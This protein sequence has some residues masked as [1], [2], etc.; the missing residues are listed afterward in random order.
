MTPTLASH[1]GHCAIPL[2]PFHARK[3]HYKSRNGCEACKRRKKKCDELPHGCSGCL[4][5]AIPCHYHD[6]SKSLSTG[7]K[8]SVHSP[9][10]V[11]N[12]R[13]VLG[14]SSDESKLLHHFHTQ[15][16][17]TLGSSSVQEVIAGC[18]P[19]VLEFDYLKHAVF[20]L[21]AS[22]LVF[23]SD[24]HD[25]SVNHYLD[26]TLLSFRQ[27]LS[28]PISAFQV[29]AVLTSCVLLNSI[30]F[31]TGSRRSSKSWLFNGT[32][33]LQWLNLQSGLRA[34]MF[35][36]RHLLRES[37]WAAV[38]SKDAECIRGRTGASFDGESLGFERIPEKF[39]DLFRMKQNCSS[40][41]NAYD[42]PLRSLVPLLTSDPSSNSLTQLMAV[43]HRFKPEFL[44][45]IQSR[46]PRALL[47]LAHW[48]GLM[49]QVDLWWVSS[50]SRSECFA[51]CKYLDLVGDD[52]IR[53]LLSFPAQCCGYELDSGTSNAWQ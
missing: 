20:A 16:L 30:V 14:F 12:N 15:T 22:H 27:T 1:A 5:A 36:I 25:Q 33:N 37:S 9:S 29:D 26:K 35:D 47:L 4:R 6:A 49:C 28:S 11:V 24:R 40:W 46:D 2:K 21:A 41:D 50:R 18:L 44:Q 51:C 8:K 32:A 31:S 39:E 10:K 42:S 52:S 19:A 7:R 38:Y 34:I 48:L 17:S 43:M 23:L 53:G 13:G 45:L 3:G